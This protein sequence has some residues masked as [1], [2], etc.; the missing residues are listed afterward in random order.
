V[1]LT[2]ALAF[3][4]VAP[5]CAQSL[6]PVSVLVDGGVV[7][8]GATSDP[9][10]GDPYTTWFAGVTA[11]TAR[12]AMP[13]HWDFSAAAAF[14]REPTLTMVRVA[15]AILPAYL[16]A[17]A[18]SATLRF[19]HT[20][21]SVETALVARIAGTRLDHDQRLTVADNTIGD[22]TFFADAIGEL[23]W[24]G[25]GGRALRG[26]H[27]PLPLVSAY[28]GVKHDQRFHRAGDLSNFDDPT[29]R[30]EGGFFIAVWRR[31][32]RHGADAI[33]IGAGAN[34]EAALDGDNRLPGG[35]R[36][37]ARTAIDLANA[38]G[39]SR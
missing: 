28:V 23:R 18:T 38:F 21:G 25:P 16:D 39:G 37:F 34:V 22:W 20:S 31:A 24:Y 13:H 27:P 6:R 11:E 12:V 35:F 8:G 30:I 2:I 32:N 5:I 15:P 1:L 26:G 33:S 4:G 36:V 14:R 29:G 19:A 9:A 7:A 10:P 3:V 17:I